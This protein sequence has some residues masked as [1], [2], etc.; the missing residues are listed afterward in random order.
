[1]S[2]RTSAAAYDVDMQRAKSV[3]IQAFALNIG[4][5]SYTDQQLGYA[6]QS[7][8]DN[9]M[10]VFISFDFNWWSTSQGSAVGS[11]IAQYASRP[12]QLF[13]NGK[14]FVSS[15]IGDGLNVAAVREAAGRDIY[16]AP[17]YHPGQGDFSSVDGA[18]NWMAWSSNGNNKA[19][20]GGATVTVNAG[21]QA[22]R[23]AL[24]SK[25]YIAREFSYLIR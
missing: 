13:V 6:Y 10:K 2:D 14:V 5:D 20:S 12:A 8:A 9:G 25:G 23:S 21:D 22:Y 11:K 16:F 1:M 19:P 4:T 17:N 3:G 7:A 18:L 15:F 24:G